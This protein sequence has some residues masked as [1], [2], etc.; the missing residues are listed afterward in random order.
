MMLSDH[1]RELTRSYQRSVTRTNTKMGGQ[2]A[3]GAADSRRISSA[4]VWRSI[5]QIAVSFR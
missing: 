3:P 1:D 5:L 4:W 2:S